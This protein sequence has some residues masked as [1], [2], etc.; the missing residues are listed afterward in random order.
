MPTSKLNRPR[1]NRLFENVSTR[2]DG[3]HEPMSAKTLA[4]A[5]GIKRIAAYRHLADME[6]RASA[7][8]AAGSAADRR[9]GPRARRTADDGRSPRRRSR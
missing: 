3:R 4:R 9:S 2:K 8:S 6:A 5:T 1:M 7:L